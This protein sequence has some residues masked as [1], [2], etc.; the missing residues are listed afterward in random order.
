MPTIL[1]LSTLIIEPMGARGGE[2]VR[3]GGGLI[4]VGGFWG[5]QK[6]PAPYFVSTHSQRKN[7]TCALECML[8]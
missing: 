6:Q 5:G 8:F 1:V 7:I 4:G 3:G 2:G